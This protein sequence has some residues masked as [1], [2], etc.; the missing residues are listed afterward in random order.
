MALRT[1][2]SF[3]VRSSVHASV[4]LNTHISIS[5]HEEFAAQLLVFLSFLALQSLVISQLRS[6][7][8]G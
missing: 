3:F 2:C 8:A 1:G 7:S 6:Y 4:I 5:V